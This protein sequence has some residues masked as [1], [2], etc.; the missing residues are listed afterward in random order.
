MCG[1]AGKYWVNI[2]SEPMK[3]ASI[4]SAIRVMQHR[5][6]DDSGDHM[7]STPAG[8]LELGHTRLSIIDL[9]QNGHQPMSLCESRYTITFNGEIYNYRELREELIQAGYSFNTG[10]DTEVLVYSW[11]HWGLNCLIKFKGMFAFAICDSKLQKLWLVTDAFGIKPL[12]YYSDHRVLAFASEIPAL[13]N[14][15][16]KRPEFNMQSCYNYLLFGIYD[17]NEE[18]FF[19]GIKKLQPGHY[20][21]VDLSKKKIEF[22]VQRWWNPSTIENCEISFE[23]AAKQVRQL[24]LSNIRLHLRSDVPLGAA[25]SGG[26]DSS[27]VVCAM[28]ALYPDMPIHTF[29]YIARGSKVDEEKWVDLVNH[30]IGAIPHKI[31]FT[32]FDLISDLDDL[33][34]TQGEPFSSTS[35]YAQYRVFKK[36][37][38]EGITVTLDGQGADEMLAGYNG[39]PISRFKSLIESRQY[40]R[41]YKLIKHWKVTHNCSTSKVVKYLRSAI[42]SDK[43][44]DLADKMGS[45]PSAN[46]L[47]YDY[48]IDQQIL[49]KHRPFYSLSN[50]NSGRRLS[51]ALR[52]ALTWQSLQALLRHGDR[53]SMRWSIESRVPF[54]TPDLAEYILQLPEHYLLSDNGE[55]KSIFRASMRGIV[56]DAILDRQDKVGF[57]T[58]EKEIIYSIKG[59]ILESLDPLANLPFINIHH[60]RKELTS[61]LNVNSRSSL[62]IWHLFNLSRFIALTKENY[63]EVKSS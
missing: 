4:H 50:D 19:E 13:L 29:S 54:L 55:T 37:R 8:T 11:D 18:S 43:L 39:Y 30:H 31:E 22:E 40:K 42:V 41:L 46:W 7:I 48:L 45:K 38:E 15:L 14:I 51:E 21:S 34:R 2:N 20:L 49:F 25:L 23:E 53:N 16:P 62:R 57:E 6:P 61:V 63:S 59:Q 56:P 33:I 60:L 32:P 12:C 5:G 52:N 27:A 35:I 36:V 24:F 28:R 47:N 10:T 1:I 17:T 44:R 9:S 58:P 26:I 3:T